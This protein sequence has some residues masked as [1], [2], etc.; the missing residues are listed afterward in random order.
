MRRARSFS[1]LMHPVNQEEK[2]LSI[3][4]AIAHRILNRWIH[5]HL[6]ITLQIIL[7]LLAR[8]LNHGVL[9]GANL[10]NEYLILGRHNLVQSEFELA[11]QIVRAPGLQVVEV[12]NVVHGDSKNLLL[13]ELVGH[14]EAL[15]PLWVQVVH[16]DL[17]HPKHRPDAA[18]LLMEHSHAI[19]PREGVQVWQVFACKCQPQRLTQPLP[20]YCI[21]GSSKHSVIQISTHAARNAPRKCLLIFVRPKTRELVTQCCGYVTHLVNLFN[22]FKKEFFDLVLILYPTQI[23][24][25]MNQKIASETNFANINKKIKS[26]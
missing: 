24:P 2:Y 23:K 17:G 9:L 12:I 18:L 25:L 10:P 1:L 3:N 4:L 11:H 26:R 13:L 14:I 19:G 7:E 22:V 21:I 6:L 15:N 16:D 8:D 20:M 5:E